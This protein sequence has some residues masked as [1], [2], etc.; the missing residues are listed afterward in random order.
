MADTKISDLPA[1]TTPAA[2]DEFA[3]AQGGVSKKETRAQLHALESGEHLVL[4]QVNEPLTPT[5]AFGSGA[6]TGFYERND[7]QLVLA[8]NGAGHTR[9]QA[10]GVDDLATSNGYKL[11]SENSTNNNPV[12]AFQ[13]DF[14]SGGGWAGQ[15][16][17]NKIAGGVEAQR[18]TEVT[19]AVLT[20][21]QGDVGL[22]AH[23]DSVQGAGVIL[24]SYNVYST[25]G[26]TG[27]AATLPAVFTIDPSTLVYVKNDGANSMDVF[28]ASGDDAGAGA[29]TA[30]AVAAGDFAVFMATAANSTWTKI[31]GGTA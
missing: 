24:S 11:L 7:A 17:P 8:N 23:T 28:P 31:M 14:D 16:A 1:V 27:D 10:S 5:L 3:V 21:V 19:S 6:N 20:A 13:L 22:T 15:D 12:Y 29:D 2:T 25:V 18:W 4:P 9:F 30:V 26:T